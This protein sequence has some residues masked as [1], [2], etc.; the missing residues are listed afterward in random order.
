MQGELMIICH[1]F[2]LLVSRYPGLTRA[3]VP[4]G[5]TAWLKV[6]G[7]VLTILEVGLT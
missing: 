4:Y 5:F 7:R 3:E 6:S 2:S 1:A